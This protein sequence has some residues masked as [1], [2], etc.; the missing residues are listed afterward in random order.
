MIRSG[1]VVEK[2]G[3][4]LGIVFERPAACANCSGCFNKHCSRVQIIG[5]AEIGDTVEVEMPDAN[6]VKASAL[7]YI[8]P[9]CTFLLGLGI[10]YL[11]YQRGG[12][13]LAEDLFYAICGVIACALGLFTVWLIDKKLG[14]KHRLQPK[15]IAVHK[16]TA[17]EEN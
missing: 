4:A 8:I 5:E 16:G 9:V 3:T 10:G 1:T 14:Q 7:M 2:E 12:I 6:L 17:P 11:V 13:A 15:I